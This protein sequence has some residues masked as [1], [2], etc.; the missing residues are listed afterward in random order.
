MSSAAMTSRRRWGGSAG[1]SAVELMAVVGLVS[2][3][4][5]FA[6]STLQ[7]FA[8]Q[9]R[10][11]GASGLVATELARAHHEAI[12]T[13]LCHYFEPLGSNRFRIRRDPAAAPTCIL[14]SG[15][16]ILR[17]VDLGT[18]VTFSAG[19]ASTGPYGAPITAG[20]PSS[21]RFEPRGL[22]T[23]TGGSIIFLHALDTSPI[24]V[25]VSAAGSVRTW[26][27]T[28]GSWE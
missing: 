17:T 28:G 12:R 1:L 9:F 3:S 10:L 2:V 22:V 18:G 13:R 11:N 26:R 24:A 21:L 19:G 4:S 15:A 6:F 8:Q 27:S 23:A 7:P 5:M 20:V 16:I 25:S 14:G